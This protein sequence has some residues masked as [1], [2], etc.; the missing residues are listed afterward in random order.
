[1]RRPGANIDLAVEFTITEE[2][3]AML[4]LPHGADRYDAK[5]YDK[6]KAYTMHHAKSWYEHLNQVE[7]RGARNGSLYLVTGCDK[8][9]S[10][11]L[12]AGSPH[13]ER[14]VGFNIAGG[15]LASGTVGIHASWRNTG[16]V[17]SRHY[18]PSITYTTE[19]ANQ[20]VFARGFVIG[21]NENFFKKMWAGTV[22]TEHM[23]SSSK[24]FPA[25]SSSVPFQSPPGRSTSPA[26]ATNQPPSQSLAD[27]S[28]PGELLHS[29]QDVVYFDNSDTMSDVV[30]LDTSEYPKPLSG[31][32]VIM[33]HDSDWI[34][35]T[36][37]DTGNIFTPDGT[38]YDQL[39]ARVLERRFPAIRGAY[40]APNPPVHLS[41]FTTH[42]LI[43][44]SQYPHSSTQPRPI[45]WDIS[46]P[47]EYA[48]HPSDPS[49][50]PLSR[51]DLS[52]LAT[53]PAISTLHIVCDIFP[54][55]WPI[56]VSRSSG[57][58]IGDV[59]EAIHSTLIK[60]ISMSDWD[61]LSQK[62]E[63]RVK[64]AFERRCRLAPDQDA[65]RSQGVIRLDC[66]VEHTWFRG[67]SVS[68]ETENTCI[69][70]L[71]RQTQE[72]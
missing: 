4:V 28:S 38:D 16:G 60:P 47:S 31:I 39:T 3:A 25:I 10:W 36:T 18:P 34:T 56:K 7:Q 70:S 62:Q 20:C 22:R 65:C 48:R 21:I 42:P 67:L 46:E 41:G 51:S 26:T 33:V 2:R 71:G 68:V 17:E 8:A 6:Y 44:Y 15:A 29:E 14:T 55:N 54:S 30:I 63:T 9:R 69:M 58:T 19:N 66:L 52:Q 11:G 37:S 35:A 50:N 57:V 5:A 24:N 40:A 72:K 45:T 53:K 61:A 1:M 64:A 43:T 27:N 32:D 59:L 13:Q 49:G 23:T 12:A